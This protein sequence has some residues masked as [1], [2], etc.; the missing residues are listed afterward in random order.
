LAKHHILNLA[1]PVLRVAHSGETQ[2]AIAKEPK[3]R[4]PKPTLLT[5]DDTLLGVCQALGHDFGFNPF[6]LRALLG[7]LLL[8]NPV[9]I[10]GGYLGAAIILGVIRWIYPDPVQAAPAEAAPAAAQAAEL[11][12][13]PQPQPLAA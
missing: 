12:L 11:V 3:M 5:R 2:A 4:L 9:A 6:F 8:W 13:E 10:V 1:R 7:V